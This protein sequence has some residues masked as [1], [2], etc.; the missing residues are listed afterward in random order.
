MPE[1][2]QVDAHAYRSHQMVCLFVDF[3]EYC[4]S[5][6]LENQIEQEQLWRDE[7]PGGLQQLITQPGE[8]VKA[9]EEQVS[10]ADSRPYNQQTTT[11]TTVSDTLLYTTCVHTHTYFF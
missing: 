8:S 9:A 3:P 7:I 11:W 6:L 5:R 4:G 1:F 2:C 10:H